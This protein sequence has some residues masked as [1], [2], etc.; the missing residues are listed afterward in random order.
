MEQAISMNELKSNT[1]WKLWG[2]EDP[3]WG[4]ASWAD[5][6]KGGESPW[7]EDEFYALGESDYQDFFRQWQHYGVKLESCLEIGCGAGRLTR[8]LAKTFK[9][10]YA[11][12]VSEEMIGFARKAVGENVQFS[13]VDGLHLPYGDNS[14]DAVFSALVLQHL[15]DVEIGF[16]YFREFFRVLEID[17]TMMIQIPVYRFPYHSKTMLF[18]MELLHTATRRLGTIQANIKRRAG[19]KMMRVTPYPVEPLLDLLVSLGFKNIEFRM[20]ATKSNGDLNSF[21]FA[22]KA[23]AE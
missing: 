4:V 16:S 23:K 10:V 2:K 3:L 18:L 8:Q 12:D 21:V 5:K 1:E 20:F 22:T 13:V 14:V 9:Q 15:D 11:V 7:T 6:R 17:G 19:L